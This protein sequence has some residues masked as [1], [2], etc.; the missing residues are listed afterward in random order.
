MS[1]I[2]PLRVLWANADS[3]PHQLIYIGVTAIVSHMHSLYA[4]EDQ[5]P[6]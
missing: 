3:S 6:D 2:S 5:N 1:D 4:S